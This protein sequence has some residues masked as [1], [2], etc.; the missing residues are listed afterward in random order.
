M[1]KKQLIEKL[2]DKKM[3]KIL[4]LLINNPEKEFYLREISRQT[5][6]PVATT[7]RII[8]LLKE[9]ELID[10]KKNKYLKVYRANQKN[11]SVFSELLEDKSSALREFVD[12]VSKLS[13]ISQLILHGEEYKD[14]ASIF[15]IGTNSDHEAINVK[16][17]E[18]KEKFAFNI[19]HTFLSQNQYEQ[20]TSMG[21]FSGKK[22]NLFST[23]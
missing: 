22:V 1:D 12:Y 10:E 11:I 13:G 15:I 17:V 14:K 18:I 16:A 19:I 6:V 3:I 5:K 20:M 23:K 21:L 4:R 9:V 8:K 7:F 2:F